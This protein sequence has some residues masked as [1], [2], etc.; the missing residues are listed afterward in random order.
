MTAKKKV[1]FKHKAWHDCDLGSQIHIQNSNP[2]CHLL[3]I[4]SIHS[5]SR[6]N[7][8]HHTNI[9]GQGFEYISVFFLLC[10]KS[11]KNKTT[12]LCLLT[13]ICLLYLLITKHQETLYL[14]ASQVN[15]LSPWKNETAGWFRS[16]SDTFTLMNYSIM[17]RVVLREI[18]S[19][20]AHGHRW[21]H[22]NREPTE[23]F[24]CILW[25]FILGWDSC[26]WC[27]YIT[28]PDTAV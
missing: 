26:M 19:A 18:L 14:W 7:T 20:P 12:K 11:A 28:Q 16:S 10:F 4:H 24:W 9:L 1:H 13:G 6:L 3:V 5:N 22:Q 8:L 2:T 21:M 25:Y 17:K 15:L 27:F 23:A